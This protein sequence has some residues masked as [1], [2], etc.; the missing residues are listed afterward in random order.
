MR[1]V[2]PKA[3][4]KEGGGAAKAKK[5][6]LKSPVASAVASGSG[7]AALPSA[8]VHLILSFVSRADWA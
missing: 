8:V 7:L 6:T 3:N 4:R 2:L 5:A 1:A